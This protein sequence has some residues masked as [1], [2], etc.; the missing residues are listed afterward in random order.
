L[1]ASNILIQ[2]VNGLN[3]V[4]E[5][6]HR[7]LKP[8]NIL[9]HAGVWKLSDFGI[10][11]FVEESTSLNTMKG[12]MTYAYAAPEQ[13][14]GQR[15]S[16]A[17]DLYAVGCIAYE[18]ITGKPPYS[19]PDSSSYQQQHIDGEI[20]LLNCDNSL[21]RSLVAMLLRKPPESR[22]PRNRVSELLGKIAAGV[23]IKSHSPG[24]SNIAAIGAREAERIA[25]QERQKEVKRIN[26]E[27]RLHLAME[28]FRI[29]I[30]LKENLLQKL[31]DNAIT[32]KR[33]G[34]SII[35]GNATLS[36]SIDINRPFLENP[37]DS[38]RYFL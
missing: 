11:R 5:I 38:A 37:F 3:E 12:F 4:D 31:I 26:Q 24:L 18:L 32:A 13:W 28:A 14:K 23:D 33:K 22:P 8:E 6:V 10:S 30:E 15:V 17:T 34:D 21:M 20:P 35:L 9:Y 19:G 25:E 16:S 7:D 36:F 29:L 1:E 27:K 2:I